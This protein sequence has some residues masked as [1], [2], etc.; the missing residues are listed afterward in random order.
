[1]KTTKTALVCVLALAALLLLTACGG[2]ADADTI[3]IAQIRSTLDEIQTQVDSLTA[4][5]TAAAAEAEAASEPEETAE[6][7]PTSTPEP[8]E[9]PEPPAE[10]EPTPEPTEEPEPTNTP[11]EDVE[12]AGSRTANGGNTGSNSAAPAQNTPVPTTPEPVSAPERDDDIVDAGEE[13]PAPVVEP[14]GDSGNEL[15]IIVDDSGD[16]G[17]LD[18]ALFW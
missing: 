4:A 15:P 14:A 7:E 2:A 5:Y 9:E 17:C 13:A 18:D 12:D 6:P 10:P 1:M 11:G 8:T 3:M 16:D